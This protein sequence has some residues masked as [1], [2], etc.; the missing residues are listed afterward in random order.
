MQDALPSLSTTPPIEDAPKNRRFFSYAEDYQPGQPTWQEEP[1][2]SNARLRNL[3]PDAQALEQAVW[4]IADAAALAKL[5]GSPPHTLRAQQ[6]L[7]RIFTGSAG[8]RPEVPFAR[9]VPRENP[10][11]WVQN[12]VGFTALND[13]PLVLLDNA[14]LPLA[15]AQREALAMWAGCAAPPAA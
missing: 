14:A 15:P 2:S 1:G 8:M 3:S 4:G 10:E 5:L 12:P 13:M 9:V 7:Q 6:T 11:Q